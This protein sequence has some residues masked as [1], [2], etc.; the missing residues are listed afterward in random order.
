[1]KPELSPSASPTSESV[2]LAPDAGEQA[3]PDIVEDAATQGAAE[4]V[5]VVGETADGFGA[6]KAGHNTFFQGEVAARN[7]LRLVGGAR[8]RRRSLRRW[9]STRRPGVRS[10]C[11]SNG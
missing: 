4:N 1:M 9:R 6:I 8:T 11:R 3:A 10:R 5:L 7:V 2:E